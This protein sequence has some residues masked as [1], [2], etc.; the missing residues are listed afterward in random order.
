MT[1]FN[2]PRIILKSGKDRSVKR[3]HPWIFSGA[4]KKIIGGAVDGENVAVFDNNENFLGLGHYQKNGSISVRVFTFKEVTPD[5]NFWKEK[6]VSAIKTRE[7]LG[8]ISSTQTNVFRVIHGE[9]DGFPGFI[10]DYYNG[11]LVFQAHSLGMYNL[12]EV[13]KEIFLEV[14]PKEIL[15]IYDKSEKTLSKSGG[16]T[17]Q[18]KFLYGDKFQTEVNE[19]GMKFMVNVVDGQKT[20]YFIDQREN[21]NLLRQ[22]SLGKTV[23]NMFCYTGGFS[24]AA[25]KGG[26]KHV[27]SVDASQ[28]ATDLAS[29]N[30]KINSLEK[31]HE[32]VTADGFEFLDNMEKGKYDLIILD[33][34]AFAKHVSAVNQALKGYQRINCA[35][36]EKIAPGSILFTFSCSQAV[37]KLS[38]RMAVMEASIKAGRKIKI[39]HQLS[40]PSDHPISMY[41]PEGEYLKGLVLYV[42]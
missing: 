23:L 9:G 3:L 15:S 6:I 14:F 2:F 30:A 13:F 40:Q 42:E 4:I 17:V 16:T 24:I 32:P 31:N 36:M 29:E 12:E 18:N 39:L 25:L 41:H 11:I 33:P 10:C 22:Y 38:F 1:N 8:L 19:Y 34:P 35:A 27:T 37:D 28:T 7:C 21:R 20:G 26:A 5:K